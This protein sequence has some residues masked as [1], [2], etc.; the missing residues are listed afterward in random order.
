[1]YSSI[2]ISSKYIY[3]QN[4]CIRRK[5]QILA[6]YHSPPIEYSKFKNILC[7][8][9]PDC[10]G[11]LFFNICI[12]NICIRVPVSLRCVP[13]VDNFEDNFRI[14]ASQLEKLRTLPI[15]WS[16][17]QKSDFIRIKKELKICNLCVAFFLCLL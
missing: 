1:M 10:W 17:K 7:F 8:I 2:C 12:W 6:K 13:S 16:T 9:Y 15:R 14:N 4:I 3:F 11:K 5:V